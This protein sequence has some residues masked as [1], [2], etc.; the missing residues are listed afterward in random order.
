[1]EFNYITITTIRPFTISV[2]G[3]VNQGIECIAYSPSKRKIKVTSSM[4]F[5]L[6]LIDEEKQMKEMVKDI[7]SQLLLEEK[8]CELFFKGTINP[9]K[10]RR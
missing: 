6:P 4:M 2:R 7:Y 10:S 9:L 5:T 1:M 3:K 8:K